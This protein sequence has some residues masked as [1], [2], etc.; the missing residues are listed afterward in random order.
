MEELT[1]ELEEVEVER[2]KPRRLRSS[3]PRTRARPADARP[4]P[5]P[6]RGWA[7]EASTSQQHPDER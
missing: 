4:S 5:R 1:P 7:I 3:G 2:R 6:V